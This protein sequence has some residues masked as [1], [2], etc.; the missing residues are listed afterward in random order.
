MNCLFIYNPQ[1][2]KKSIETKLDYIR[3]MLLQKFQSVDI[4]KSL[5]K[6]DLINSSRSACGKYDS[7]IFAGGDGT[8][9]DVLNAVAIM[10]NKPILGYIPTGT[11]NDI[12]KTYGISKNIKKALKIILE[13]HVEKRDVGKINDKYFMYVLAKGS[14]TN[15]SFETPR[16]SK[17]KYGKFAYGMWALR[18]I[19]KN[20]KFTIS[21]KC[22]YATF[23]TKSPLILVVNSRSIGGLKFNVDGARNDGTLDVFIFRGERH[24]VFLGLLYTVLEKIKFKRPSRFFDIIRDSKFSIKT[25]SSK[26]W[27]LDGERG[28]DVDAEIECVPKLISLYTKRGPYDKRTSR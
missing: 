28:D 27:C 25:S 24:S 5:S 2:G 15:V 13:G 1:S 14:F 17:K 18:E 19:S 3:T 20:E 22:S 21:I 23:T 8:F 11:A 26:Q 10:E 7:L 4:Y 12:A 16:K 6:E 9:N